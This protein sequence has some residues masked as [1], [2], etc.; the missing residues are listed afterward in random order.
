ML[1][2]DEAV[3]IALEYQAANPETL[4]IVTGDHETAGI[5]LTYDE[6]RDP[7]M[8]YASGAHTGVLIPLFASGPGADRFSGI[9]RNDEVGRILLELVRGD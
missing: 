5:T 7:I 3:A 9:I 2:M 6:N 1:D 4:V 8:Q